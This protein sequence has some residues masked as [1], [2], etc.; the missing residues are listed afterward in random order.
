MQTQLW[1]TSQRIR[2]PVQLDDPVTVLTELRAQTERLKSE[3]DTSGQKQGPALDLPT[4]AALIPPNLIRTGMQLYTGL[5][6]SRRVAPTLHGTAAGI[7]GPP[8]P[9]YCAGAQVV[10]IHAVLPLLEGAGLNITMVSHDQATDVS[11]SA[12]PDNVTAVEAILDGI[13]DAVKELQG[14]RKKKNRPKKH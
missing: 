5:A 7:A 3:R 2:L 9:V 6:R 14:M 4:V 10:G 13:V 11:V 8:V 12:C 1:S